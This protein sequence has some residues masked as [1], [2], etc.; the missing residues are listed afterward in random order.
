M[1]AA[2]GAEAAGGGVLVLGG[3][4]GRGAAQLGI[5]RALAEQGFQPDACVGTSVGALNAAVVAALP[6]A[7]AV[8]ALERIWAS[9]QTRAV[10]RRRPLRLVVNRAMRRPWLRGDE[11]IA[12]L[13]DYAMDLVG[14]RSFEALSRPLRIIVTDL[15]SGEPVV[16]SEGPLRDALR[17]S[18]AIPFVFPPVRLGDRLYVD[19]GVTDN[20][21]IAT[22]ARMHPSRILA[23]DLTAEPAG[24]PWRRF[25][26]ILDR[27]TSMALHARVVADYDRFS[28]RVPVTLICPRFA[29]RLKVADFSAIREAA[30]TATESLLQE[31]RRTDGRLSPGVFYLPLAAR[32]TPG[33][34]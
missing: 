6:L 29:P 10:F 24:T 27:V 11:P 9:P 5:L 16:I 28:G 33:S 14:V 21:S 13:V 22:A 34:R 2:A 18:C 4:G 1:G 7:E 30:R 12:E 8:D 20:C 19:G 17:A 3:G 25:S 32:E 26:D 31:I 23:V 15:S